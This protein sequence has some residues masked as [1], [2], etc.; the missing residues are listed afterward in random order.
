MGSV[1]QILLKHGTVLNTFLGPFQGLRRYLYRWGTALVSHSP[2]S[3]LCSDQLERAPVS[4]FD[5]RFKLL[6]SF[7]MRVLRW[8]LYCSGVYILRTIP[9][10]WFALGVRRAT[11]AWRR[12]RGKRETNVF[13]PFPFCLGP[14]LPLS[15]TGKTP[16]P[17]GS[18][19]SW[20][21]L[22]DPGFW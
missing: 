14:L 3:G 1:M 21:T 11:P 10:F 12:S 6:S 4:K 15:P 19:F 18:H 13:L 5:L 20:V 22:D 17:H 16:L 8:S 9:C 2:S 7:R